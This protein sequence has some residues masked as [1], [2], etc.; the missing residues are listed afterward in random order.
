MAIVMLALSIAVFEIIANQ[1]KCQKFD[2]ENEGQAQLEEKLDL[3]R[4]TGNCR[5][6]LA[7]FFQNFIQPATYVYARGYTHSHTLTQTERDW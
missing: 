2:L 3:R 5:F 7:D 6:Y 1:I 4:S